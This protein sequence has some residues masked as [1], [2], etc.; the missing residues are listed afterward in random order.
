MEQHAS[1]DLI[2][3]NSAPSI[4]KNIFLTMYVYYTWMFIITY[5]T[6]EKLSTFSKTKCFDLR[7]Y[8]S[9]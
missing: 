4:H 1:F 3:S 9:V 5:N 6:L 2:D 8:N 7:D